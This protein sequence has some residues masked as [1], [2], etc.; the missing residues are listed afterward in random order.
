MNLLCKRLI[1]AIVALISVDVSAQISFDGFGFNDYINDAAVDTVSGITGIP[2]GYT[3]VGF[4]VSATVNG[5]TQTI[6]SHSARLNTA[7]RQLMHNVKQGS[8]I[9]VEEIQ[10]RNNRTERV[11]SEPVIT[12]IKDGVTAGIDGNKILAYP[13]THSNDT[14]LY[15]VTSFDVESIRPDFVYH[16]RISGNTIDSAAY[17]QI[18]KMGYRF[19]VKNIMAEEV[20]TGRKEEIRPFSVTDEGGY[21][22][23][24]RSKGY[25]TRKNA[26][27]NFVYPMPAAIDSVRG[28]FHTDKGKES[29]SFKGNM[30]SKEAQKMI[31]HIQPFSIITFSIYYEGR[32]ETI[33]VMAID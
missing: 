19:T 26:E 23:L 11:S 2:E 20:A 6:E 8:K 25:L 22:Y 13:G 17:A 28:D 18:T 21:H 31:K 10:I 3:A 5:F 14:T 12:L 27:V 16:M 33:N 7:Q 24:C 30:M 1:I 9:Y 15:R 4:S 29:F 32:E